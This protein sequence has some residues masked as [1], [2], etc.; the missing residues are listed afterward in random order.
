M[1]KRSLDQKLRLRNFDAR[2]G[3]FETGAVVKSRKGSTGVERGKGICYRGK[4]KANVRRETSAV[5][6]TKVINVQNRH[7]KPALSSER[8]TPRG[9]SAPTTKGKRIDCNISNYPP[10]VV[11]G[12]STSSSASSTP[13]SSTSS[14]Q[15]SV[16]DTENP[17][18]EWKYECSVTGKPVA[19]TRRNQKHI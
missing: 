9:R 10:L 17:A 2:H 18:A 4:K 16:I 5:S 3:K 13:T 1:V 7:R 19:K 11:P 15:D 8:P 12:L 14:S 6:G